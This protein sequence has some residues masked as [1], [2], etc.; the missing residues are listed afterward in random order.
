MRQ[1]RNTR[2][3]FHRFRRSSICDVFRPNLPADENHVSLFFPSYV[4]NV[5]ASDDLG[6]F[7]RGCIHK[8]STLAIVRTKN[9]SMCFFY[10]CLTLSYLQ[11]TL[12]NMYGKRR[13]PP[14]P[15][16]SFAQRQHGINLPPWQR[17]CDVH[18]ALP[19]I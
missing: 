4:G 8:K 11:S 12:T 2:A 1:T 14:L 18:T 9:P 5:P 15:L 16:T 10:L 6:I 3:S 13:E 19:W 7:G 17:I